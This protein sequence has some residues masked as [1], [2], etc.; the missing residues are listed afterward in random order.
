MQRLALHF[1]QFAELLVPAIDVVLPFGE[2]SLIRLDH[3]LLLAEV[4]LLLREGLL[5]LVE[6]PL[7]FAQLVADARQLA[8]RLRL[9]S[10]LSLLDRELR[11]FQFG[12]SLALGPL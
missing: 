3:F 1:E 12:R 10:E 8:L 11:F 2:P 6:R 5:P 4:V 7:A 9:R